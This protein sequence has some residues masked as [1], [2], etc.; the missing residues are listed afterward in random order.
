MEIKSYSF[1][2]LQP[3]L[4]HY[5]ENGL[6]NLIPLKTGTKKPKMNS[7]KKYQ[8]ERYPLKRLK[9]H[10]GNYAPYYR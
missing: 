1:H 5:V 6:I 2:N 10:H 4:K 8:S 3:I 7:W 9:R